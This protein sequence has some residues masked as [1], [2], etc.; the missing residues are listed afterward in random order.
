METME[1]YCDSCKK[2]T[3]NKSSNV[4]KNKQKRLMLLLNCAACGKNEPT[5]IKNKELHN[6]D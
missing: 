2:Y 6:F 4:R 5:F 1:T 3:E